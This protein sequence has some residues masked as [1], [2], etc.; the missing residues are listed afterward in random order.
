M[1]QST[2]PSLSQTIWP[3]WTSRHFLSVSIVQTL[4]PVTFGYSLSS[5]D[6]VVMRQLRKGKRPSRSCGNGTTSSF[7]PKEITSKGTRFLCMYYQKKCPH[8]K[9]LE[10]Y[11]MHLVYLCILVYWKSDKLR[12]YYDVCFVLVEFYGMSTILGY[13]M[14]NHLY[15]YILNIYDLI[16]LDFMAYQPF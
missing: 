5:R 2:T 4:L 3:R 1:Y 13:S 14:P 7:Q 16:W 12:G 11:R 6:A 15:K 8:E 9:S 10:T